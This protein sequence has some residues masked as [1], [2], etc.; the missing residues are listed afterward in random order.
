MPFPEP[1]IAGIYLLAAAAAVLAPGPDMAFFLGAAVRDGVKA[2]LVAI[3]GVAAG[4]LAHSLLAAFGLSVLILASPTLFSALKIAGALYLLWLALQALRSGAF[5]V[6]SQ[7]G[8]RGRGLASIFAQG[9]AIN[10]LNPKIIVFFM[11]FLPQFVAASDP[12]AGARLFLLGLAYIGVVLVL[13]PPMVVMAHRLTGFLRD[14]PLASKIANWTFAGVF[15]AFAIGLLAA[16]R[17]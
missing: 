7:R 5:P 3:A 11:T 8:S 10:L 4:L 2:G 12:Q 6:I 13:T 1:H 14:N 15:G 17:I 9:F 16:R